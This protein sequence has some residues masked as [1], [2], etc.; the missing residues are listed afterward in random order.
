LQEKTVNGGA[1]Q[2]V[3]GASI[4]FGR[5]PVLPKKSGGCRCMLNG[6]WRCQSGG[7][8]CIDF[9]AKKMKKKRREK[10]YKFEGKKRGQMAYTPRGIN[11]SINGG[12]LL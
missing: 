4:F 5:L 11:G 12:F 6:E 7:S 10:S 8:R 1:S 2:E 3:A 9:L